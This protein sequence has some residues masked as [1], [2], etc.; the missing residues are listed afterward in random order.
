[1]HSPI[2]PFATRQE[3]FF[4]VSVAQA[5]MLA[6]LGFRLPPSSL[7]PTLPRRD[8]TLFFRGCLASFFGLFA[9]YLRLNSRLRGYRC[10]ATPA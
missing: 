7:A 6:I 9:L 1:M 2:E 5:F 8:S 10:A 4:I 3:F